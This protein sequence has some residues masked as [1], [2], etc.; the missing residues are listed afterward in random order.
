MFFFFWKVVGYNEVARI[1]NAYLS[2]L[3]TTF[4]PKAWTVLEREPKWVETEQG[5]TK[6][7]ILEY[8]RYKNS[9]SKG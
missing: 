9:Y 7:I 1:D 4:V 5:D 8:L 6:I 2:F 3:L